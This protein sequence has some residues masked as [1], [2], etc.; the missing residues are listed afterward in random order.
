MSFFMFVFGILGFGG[1]LS[2][3]FTSGRVYV[4]ITL[5]IAAVSLLISIILGL[6]GKKNYVR[7]ALRELGYSA[8]TLFF[9]IFSKKG[10]VSF[11]VILAGTAL[12]AVMLVILPDPSGWTVVGYKWIIG[13]LPLIVAFGFL[14]WYWSKHD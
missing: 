11:F 8:S 14:I 2:L 10:L 5:G 7:N 9:T 1:D 12:S 4:F 3:Y 6:I 13:F